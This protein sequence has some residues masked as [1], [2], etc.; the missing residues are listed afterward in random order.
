[1]TFFQ[2]LDNNKT[3]ILGVTTAALG[4]VQAYPGLQNMLSPNAYAWTMFAIGLLVTV[5]GCLNS[6]EKQ[7]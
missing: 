5:C 6:R 3:K 2:F 1:M 4:F 7:Q